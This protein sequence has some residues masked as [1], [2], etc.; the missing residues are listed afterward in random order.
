MNKYK[1]IGIYAGT[2]DPIHL[3]HINFAL[4]ALQHGMDKVYLLPEPQP[5]HKQG[6]RALEHRIAMS[7]IAI[8][9]HT[10]LG[11]IELDQHSFTTIGTL[12]VLRARFPDHV[13]TLLFGDDVIVRMLDQIGDWPHIEKL[14]GS[15]EIVVLPRIK[16]GP[17]EIDELFNLLSETTGINFKYSVINSSVR[18]ISSSEVRKEFRTQQLSTLVPDEVVEYIIKHKLYIT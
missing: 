15:V 18:D 11:V 12:P 7:E 3:G 2:F 1:K 14:A 8:K 17:S 5:R 16:T 6:V 10:G 4:S 9:N 13:I